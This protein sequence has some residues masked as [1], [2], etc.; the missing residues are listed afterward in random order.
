V[1]PVCDR[2]IPEKMLEKISNLREFMRSCIK[3]MKDETTL[4][5]LCEMIDH[6]AQEGKFVL[7]KV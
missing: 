6:C 5:E 2:T 3:L 4:N 7:H 1:P